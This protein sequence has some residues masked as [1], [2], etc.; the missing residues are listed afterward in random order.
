MISSRT[1]VTHEVRSNPNRGPVHWFR[2]SVDPLLDEGGRVVRLAGTTQD[3]TETRRAEEE[4]R[5]ANR[6]L[7]MLSRVHQALVRSIEESDLVAQFCRILADTAGYHA[8][9]VGSLDATVPDGVHLTGLTSHEAAA[10]GLAPLA[11]AAAS[12]RAMVRGDVDGRAGVAYS[13]RIGADVASALVILAPDDRDLDDAE[14]AL[15]GE[16]AA[17]LAFGVHALRARTAH[18]V[19]Q[20]ALVRSEARFRATFEQAAVG[21]AHV[22]PEGRFIRVNRRL[23]EITGYSGDDLVR[24][25]LAESHIPTASQPTR[26][27]VRSC[28]RAS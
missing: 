14:V 16:L 15:I 26:T 20:D 5:R 2:T 17:D 4:L 1:P 7:L 21:V 22:S 12:E 9:C 25:T 24:G 10:P 13:L 6:E 3:V 18:R 8:V 19:V 27:I 23:A 11:G 28:S